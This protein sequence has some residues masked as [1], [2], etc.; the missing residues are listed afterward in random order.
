METKKKICGYCQ[1]FKDGKCLE[2]KKDT[3][4]FDGEDCESYNPK[5]PTTKRCSSC[6]R[7]LPVDR[8]GHHWRS[9]DGLK[10]ICK[11][12]QSA[13]IAKAM[14]KD[15]KEDGQ[16]PETEVPKGME[17]LSEKD[18]DHVRPEDETKILPLNAY[19]DKE[20]YEE[21]RRRGWDGVLQKT[22]VLTL[23]E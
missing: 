17:T 11:E 15:N 21:L 13:T 4:F 23:G 8:F 7:E 20:L 5:P 3:G 16:H 12:C 22:V 18:P 14:S 6:G 10:N 1:T 9:A 19:S 2:K